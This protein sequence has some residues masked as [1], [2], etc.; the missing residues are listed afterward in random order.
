MFELL[1]NT[2]GFISKTKIGGV[3]PLD[4]I[5]HV[6]VTI[7]ITNFLVKRKVKMFHVYFFIIII[8][9]IK[10]YF[11]SFVIGSTM[12]EHVKDMGVNLIYPTIVLMIRKIKNKD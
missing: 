3:V 6:F 10:E 8:G 2:L 1:H 4:I 12:I 7:L 11:D 5:A 9:I